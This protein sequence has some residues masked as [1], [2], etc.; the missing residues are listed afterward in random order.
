MSDK[1]FLSIISF[2]FPVFLILFSCGEIKKDIKEP[3]GELLLEPL[4]ATIQPDGHQMFQAYVVGPAIYTPD[5]PDNNPIE[6]RISN[7]SLA[8]LKIDERFGSGTAFVTGKASGVVEIRVEDGSRSKTA[9]LFI[10]ASSTRPLELS[11]VE[12]KEDSIFVF[13]II[14]S[15]NYEFC[16]CENDELGSFRLFL[17]EVEVTSSANLSIE[18]QEGNK[19][20]TDSLRPTIS[21]SP[22]S[23]LSVG[24]HKAEIQVTSKLGRYGTYSWSFQVLETPKREF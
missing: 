5:T 9:T 2:I 10:D 16:I 20:V 7:D 21:Y 23:P 14:A 12:P 18:Y 19:W 1:S 24:Q 15:L 6:W 8:T 3:L 11:Y 22:P 17:D 4:K 13:S